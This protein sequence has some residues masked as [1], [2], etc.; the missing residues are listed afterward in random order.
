M[1]YCA[2]SRHLIDLDMSNVKLFFL[3]L[4]YITNILILVYQTMVD[5]DW[6]FRLR[7]L[8]DGKPFHSCNLYYS[9]ETGLKLVVTYVLFLLFY[10]T[11]VLIWNAI[12]WLI[13]GWFFDCA[14]FQ[15]RKPSHSFWLYH[16]IEKYL[17]KVDDVGFLKTGTLCPNIPINFQVIFF[18]ME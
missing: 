16:S 15:N 14:A 11:N 7:S 1:D 13:P 17:G 5:C 3:L 9:I 8:S 6:F 4:F 18:N 12:R 2:N 10:L